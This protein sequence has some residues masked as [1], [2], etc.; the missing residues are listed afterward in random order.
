MGLATGRTRNF[1]TIY[2]M[3]LGLALGRPCAAA[4]GKLLTGT[5]VADTVASSPNPVR[6]RCLTPGGN[7]H[8][9]NEAV[10]GR[11]LLPGQAL[12]AEFDTTIHC[13]VLRYNFEYETT[14]DPNTTGRGLM[15]ISRPLD[16][17]TDEEYIQRVGHLTDPPPH[18]SVFFDAHMQA[19]NRYW[20]TVSGG[21]IRLTWDIY[22]PARDSIYQLSEPMSHYGKCDFLEVVGGLEDFFIDCI[23][24]ADTVSP[25][26]DFSQY[27]AFFLF[28][29]GADGQNDIGFPATCSDLFSGYIRF[30]GEVLVD[31]GACSVSSALMMPESAVQDGR[32]TALNAV[33]AHEFGHQL[34]LV[35]LYNTQNFFSQVG[36]FALMDNNGFG[37]GIDFGWP[38]GRVFGAIPLFPCAWSRAFLGLDE[39]H[40]LRDDTTNVEVVAA[41]LRA[42]PGS[43]II[44]LPISET[45]YYL[46]ENRLDEI[47]GKTTYVLADQTTS[48]VQ[49]PVDS[50]RAFTGEY[51]FLM[52]GSG[53]LIY[54][55]DEEVAALDYDGDGT[56]NFFDNDLQWFRDERKFVKLIE[57]DGIVD[58]G[59]NYRSGFGDQGDFFRDDLKT[60]FTPNSNPGT[61][62]NTGNNTHFYVRNIERLEVDSIG[63]VGQYMFFDF[64]IDRMAE[65]FPVRAGR[66]IM[67]HAP[68]VDDLDGDGTVEIITAAR[69]MLSVVTTTGEDFIK[70]ISTCSSCPIY[71]DVDTTSINTGSENN[72]AARYPVPVYTWLSEF[73]TAGPVTGQFDPAATER[74]VAVGYRDP[75]QSAFGAVGLFAPVDD[76]DDGMADL[77]ATPLR[78]VGR[79]QELSFGDSLLYVVTESGEI[80]RQTV[81]GASAP[82]VGRFAADTIHGVCRFGDNLVV[83]AGDSLGAGEGLTT[84][85]HFVSDTVHTFEVEGFYSFGPI[86]VDIDLDGQHEVV[87]ASPYGDIMLYTITASGP[88]PALDTYGHLVTGIELTTDPMVGDVDLDGRPDLIIGSRNFILAFNSDLV[89]KT[90]FPLEI[91]DR[92]PSSAVIAAPVMADIQAGGIP[93]LIFPTSV[94]NFYSIGG[95]ESYGFPLSSGRQMR[96]YSGSSAVTFE[97]STGGLLGYLGGDGWFYA[98]QVDADAETNFWPMNGGGPG[99]T[100][101]FDASKLPGLAA[102]STEFDERR[103]YNYPNPVRQGQ[104]RIRYFLGS[105]ARTVQLNIY[106]LSGVRVAELS[107]P[108]RGGTDHEVIWDCSQL[109]S[110]VYRCVIEVDYAGE[111]HTAFKDIAIIQ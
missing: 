11:G 55:V 12:G 37:T 26:I 32:A 44:R 53:M 51:D 86:N 21:Q 91:D 75:V 89:L 73:I 4:E 63:R 97:D 81:P 64:E 78:T 59:G 56:I 100:F 95:E 9:L 84:G 48:V 67:G 45:E 103:F 22:P 61:I 50:T 2:I 102:A 6:H 14:D 90:D 28:H 47:D 8:R 108:T 5:A 72:P 71:Y 33:M 25:E 16:T 52:P 109:V 54:L 58:F 34:G 15:D 83:L 49:G 87:I 110:G 80:H 88:E 76:N 74:L 46:V 82:L 60:F 43:K 3:L 7:P 111:S 79:P 18:D 27:E 65:G 96:N 17:L 38:V 20:E 41:E 35:D 104:T 19:L 31:S 69:N 70:S 30:G 98:W 99:G 106:D 85:L 94:G 13:L 42:D 105:D 62:D 40:D 101:V 1:L 36:D 92:F 10:A 66:P 93:E 39:V 29:A 24:L 57:A 107:G 23:T 68:I 77:V